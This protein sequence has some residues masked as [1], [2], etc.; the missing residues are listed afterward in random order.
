MRDPE[1]RAAV[2]HHLLGAFVADPATLVVEELGLRHGAA[3]VD[4]AVINGELHGYELKSDQDTLRRLPKQVVIYNSVLDR[5]TLVVA[6][7]HLL[8]AVQVVPEWWDIVIA[9]RNPFGS[10]SFRPLRTGSKNTG[11]SPLAVAKL[12]WRDE[13]LRLLEALS[14]A[15]GLRS[16]PRNAIYGRLVALMDLKQIQA[17][18]REQLKSRKDWRFVEPQMKCDG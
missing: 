13:A 17:C 18:V 3:R 14:A 11:V 12:L 15:D 9:E 7:H 4:I 16:K 6:P 1:L 10:I 5:V 8:C 2:K